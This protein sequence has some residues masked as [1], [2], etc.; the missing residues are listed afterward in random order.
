MNNEKTD[1]K[2]A[3][4]LRN[5]L[6]SSI[7]DVSEVHTVAASSSHLSASDITIGQEVF[8]NKVTST[9]IVYSLPNKSN[10]VRL[11]VGSIYMN[12][13]LEDLSPVK[14]SANKKS[15]NNISNSKNKA[16]K[17]ASEININDLTAAPA[18]P[19]AD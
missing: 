2:K 4:A 11:Q 17:I 19:P 15:N 18:P 16:Q 12:A 7:N 6:N 10:E 8:F 5:K 9:G 14:A 3:N 13:K 1:L